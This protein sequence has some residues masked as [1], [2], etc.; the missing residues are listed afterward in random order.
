MKIKNG[1]AIMLFFTVNVIAMCWYSIVM[2]KTM[3]GSIAVCY[4][5]AIGAY[6]GRK[7]FAEYQT[8]KQQSVKKV[9]EDGDV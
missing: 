3:D 8:I 1:N 6:V 7:S 9:M 5:A 4:T 2:G